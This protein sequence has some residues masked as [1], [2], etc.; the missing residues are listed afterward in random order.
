MATVIPPEHRLDQVAS[1]GTK[2]A[3]LFYRQLD[4]SRGNINGLYHPTLAT[5]IWNGNSV[6]GLDDIIKFY[7][8]L[9]PTETTLMTVDAQP[10]L[11]LPTF[12]G[13]VTMTV[14]CAGR[15]KVGD[16]T[17]FFNESFLLVAENNKWKVFADT[18]RDFS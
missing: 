5:L 11:D 16:K 3:E 10:I 15:M 6:T 1:D 9:P 4:K 17:K 7:E 12:N 18:Y 2:F 14:T 8:S 13:Q